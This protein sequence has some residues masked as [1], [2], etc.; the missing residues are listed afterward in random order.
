ML[1]IVAPIQV[2]IGDAHGLNTLA[3]QPAK[4]AAIEAHWENHG[5]E[6]VPLILFAWP[7][8]AAEKN[9]YEVAIPRIGSLIL[10]HTMKGQIPG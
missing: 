7:D 1:V 9:H 2:L 4:L 6:A 3:Y 8:M 10:T 5:D